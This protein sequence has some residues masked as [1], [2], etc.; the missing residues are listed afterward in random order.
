MVLDTICAPFVQE[1]P[2]C[3]M[4]RGTLERLLEAQRLD[5]LFARTAERHSTRAL[6]FSSFVQLM[7]AV[8]LGLHPP[9]P[10]AYQANKATLGGSTTALDN[11]LDHVATG[12]SAARVR[13]SAALAEPVVTAWQTRPPRW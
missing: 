4:A 12:V 11:K 2:S 9:V 3:V 10:A 5:A 8:V 1:R 6:L 7:S 13:D